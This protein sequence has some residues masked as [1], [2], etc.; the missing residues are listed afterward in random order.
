M[1]FIDFIQTKINEHNAGKPLS[2]RA[3][4]LSAIALAQQR[5]MTRAKEFEA[6]TIEGWVGDHALAGIIWP[7]IR[8][9]ASSAI[10]M[11]DEI[12]K[13]QAPNGG[14]YLS[15]PEIMKVK[16]IPEGDISLAQTI[17]VHKAFHILCQAAPLPRFQQAN[18]M[19]EDFVRSYGF[20]QKEGFF[21]AGGRLVDG[22]FIPTEKYATDVQLAA[23]LE[24]G[25][26][27][28]DGLLGKDATFKL[29]EKIKELAGDKD[30][31]G[32]LIG[33]GL[34][35]TEVSP[36]AHAES[37][38]DGML[39]AQALSFYYADHKDDLLNDLAGLKKGFRRFTFPGN[40]MPPAIREALREQKTWWGKTLTR[41][42]NV[43][44]TA[45]ALI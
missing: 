31:S 39:A 20:N 14:I 41:D 30:P 29:W 9:D 17:V 24:F 3:L 22:K 2:L 43:E 12:L 36:N 26:T 33:F 21:N 7:V 10:Q 28:I 13:L 27:F 18:R 25:P 44:A 38:M 19:I 16:G 5:I 8:N 42:P 34:V 23:I 11:A 37:S 35:A 40:G 4:A 1:E 32:Q 15:T 6:K 45:R